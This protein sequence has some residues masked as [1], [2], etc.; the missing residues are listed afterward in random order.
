VAS[1]INGLFAILTFMA[2]AAP[3]AAS[4]LDAR[5]TYF[6]CLATQTVALDDPRASS[7]TVALAVVT[8]CLPEGRAMYASS[9]DSAKVLAGYDTD[10]LR[11]TLARFATRVVDRFRASRQ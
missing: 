9:P 8:A 5:E 1:R 4:A 11:D 10:T 7:H 6:R 2:T 3:Q